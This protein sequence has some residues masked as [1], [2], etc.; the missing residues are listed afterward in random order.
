MVSRIFGSGSGNKE[1]G[2]CDG[3]RKQALRFDYSN[4]TG[5]AH[6]QISFSLLLTIAPP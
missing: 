3:N 1:S 2:K 6:V 5:S 4:D